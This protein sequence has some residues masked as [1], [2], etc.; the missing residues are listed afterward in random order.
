MVSSDSLLIPGLAPHKDP[1][2][3]IPPTEDGQ[4]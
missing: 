1:I 4:L 3:P 2:K